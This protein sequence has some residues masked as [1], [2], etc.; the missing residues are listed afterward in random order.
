LGRLWERDRRGGGGG[1]A[2]CW[3]VALPFLPDVFAACGALGSAFRVLVRVWVATGAGSVGGAVLD[4][5]ATD[6]HR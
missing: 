4:G 6:V 5:P 3:A 2:D 1:K